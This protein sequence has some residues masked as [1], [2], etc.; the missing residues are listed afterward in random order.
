MWVVWR[1]P[2]LYLENRAINVPSLKYRL[3]CFFPLTTLIPL[4]IR[5][6]YLGFTCPNTAQIVNC[7]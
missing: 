1:E 5:D 6:I 2:Y 7:T 4:K 3:L